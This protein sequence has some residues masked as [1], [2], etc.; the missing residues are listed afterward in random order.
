MNTFKSMLHALPK[1]RF[2]LLKYLVQFLSE[3]A[4]H[5]QQNLMTTANLSLIFAPTFLGNLEHDVYIAQESIDPIALFKE[6]T[7]TANITQQFLEHYQELF[8][9]ELSPAKAYSAPECYKP[10]TK[11]KTS[12][13]RGDHIIVF[14]ANDTDASAMVEGNFGV[15]PVSIIKTLEPMSLWHVRTKDI[16]SLFTNKISQNPSLS[17]P[18]GSGKSP[19]LIKMPTSLYQIRR[20]T[21]TMN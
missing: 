17:K 19:S 5:H 3:V 14:T 4:C 16:T 18:L 13:L 20:A 12:L 9:C 15:I 6:S 11:D 7:F 10:P 8:E 21:H 1:S 2:D